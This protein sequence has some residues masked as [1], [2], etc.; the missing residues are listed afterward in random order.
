VNSFV[1]R[2]QALADVMEHLVHT[3]LLTLVGP[4]GIG[5][6]RLA[7]EVVATRLERFVDGIC[8]VELAALTN[9]VSVPHAVVLALG[10][11][12][13]DGRPPTEV[14]VEYVR[15]REMLLVL[16]NCEHVLQ[17]SAE[18]ADR[19]I[20]A[21]PHLRILATSP[22]PLGVPGEVTWPVPP[23]DVPPAHGGL[24][25]ERTESFAAARLSCDRARAALPEFEVTADNA[26]DV[27]RVCQRLDG[28][29]LALELAAAQ[30]KV[31]TVGQIARRLNNA[32]DLLTGG[33]RLAP[34]RHQTLR[35]ALRWSYQLLPE[36]EQRLFDRLSV[37]AG[38]FS[39]EAGESVCS[40]DGVER[41]WILD[42]LARLVDRSLLVAEHQAA[43]VRYRQ[44]EPVRQLAA[45]RLVERGEQR[46]LRG[47]HADFYLAVAE[48]DGPEMDC[49]TALD[50]MDMLDRE[51]DIMRAALRW[52]L[53]I[54]DVER[55][56]QWPA[57]W[58]GSGSTVATW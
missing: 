34:A 17:P 6:T 4:V 12:D 28:T 44:L 38:S 23:L 29:P 42:G 47:R 8:L 22:E 39:L 10:L 51:H 31:L 30:I 5:K 2:G 11:Q 49:A 53:S 50:V 40:G 56:Q 25:P 13:I 57:R 41:A 33:G 52:L 35:A 9:P 7:I 32:L 3:R 37:L 14:V 43:G 21:C 1:G 45:E 16:D 18:L 46:A 24:Q 48:G 15:G 19:L 55:S 36:A 26:K 58:V 54:G 27:A 20:R